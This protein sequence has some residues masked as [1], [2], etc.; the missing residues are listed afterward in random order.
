MKIIN[1]DLLAQKC[2]VICFSANAFIKA[3][4]RL[5]MGAGAAKRVR[6]AFPGIDDVFGT[7][8]SKGITG[9]VCED[10]NICHVKY[11]SQDF[12]AVQVKRHFKDFR[13]KCWN[14]AWQ[15]MEKFKFMV[16]E[17]PDMS[18]RMN[19]PLINNCGYAGSETCIIG[20]LHELFDSCDN[21]TFCKLAREVK[22]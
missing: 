5:T 12:I 10:Y 18:F 3:N 9:L 16:G 13:E 7:R 8:L 4:G 19:V 17:N 21:I 22:I 6:D 20:K 2:D 11:N 15:S 14:L 1:E